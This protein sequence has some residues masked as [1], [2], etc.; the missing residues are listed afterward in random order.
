MQRR[1]IRRSCAEVGTSNVCM[2]RIVVGHCNDENRPSEIK[3]RKIIGY[4]LVCIHVY[5]TH[6]IMVYVQRVLRD[7]Y[8]SETSII[9]VELNRSDIIII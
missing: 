9:S 4:T 3:T 8:Y 7:T 2:N 6:I 1:Q 5:G